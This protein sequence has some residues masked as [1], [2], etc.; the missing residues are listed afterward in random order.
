MAPLYRLN[1]VVATHRGAGARLYSGHNSGVSFTFKSKVEKLASRRTSKIR[2]T[3]PRQTNCP[4][5]SSSIIA[6][7]NLVWAK[8]HPTRDNNGPALVVDINLPNPGNL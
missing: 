4:K 3:F 6:D 7:H 5:V 1:M 8:P 2:H